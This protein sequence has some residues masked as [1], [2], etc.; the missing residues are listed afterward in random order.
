MAGGGGEEGRCKDAGIGYERDARAFPREV[1]I[2]KAAC[3]AIRFLE[4]SGLVEAGRTGQAGVWEAV[5]RAMAL[6]RN[7]RGL[8][9]H[10]CNAITA[11]A[12]R[13][14]VMDTEEVPAGVGEAVAAA[15]AAFPDNDRVQESCQDA[16]VALNGGPLDGAWS[17]WPG[18][19]FGDGWQ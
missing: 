12:K 15:L 4:D 17:L 5:A 14:P 3:R 16:E 10:C 9:G 11:M 13:S 7:H 1:D 6:R 8:Q 19:V 18:D 2:Q